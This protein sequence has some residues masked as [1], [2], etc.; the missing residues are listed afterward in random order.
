MKN[1]GLA[2]SFLTL[3]DDADPSVLAGSELLSVP[4]SPGTPAKP[5]P[6]HSEP[7]P[8]GAVPGPRAGF[9]QEGRTTARTMMVGRS[10][11]HVV[12]MRR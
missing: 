1:E 7:H 2:F 8:G 10:Q 4:V 3:Y 11:S 6:A 9:P 12:G 5:G